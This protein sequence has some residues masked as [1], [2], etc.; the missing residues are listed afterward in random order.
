MW[1]LPPAERCLSSARR[2]SGL[3]L[4]AGPAHRELRGRE[5]TLGF[6]ALPSL[7][8]RLFGDFQMMQ[9]EAGE[10]GLDPQV[11]A[12]KAAGIQLVPN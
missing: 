12:L 2:L 8:G 11:Q 1:T 5:D 7:L 3:G 9:S 10:L 4:V 6:P